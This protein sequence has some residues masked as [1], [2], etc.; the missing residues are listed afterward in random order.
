MAGVIV[1]CTDG[2]EVSV[3]ALRAGLTVVDPDATFVVVS[4]AEPS[5]PSLL[6]GTGMAAGTVSP[7]LFERLEAER[8]AAAATAAAQTVATLGLDGARTEVLEGQ[9]GPSLC[10]FAAGEGASGIVMGT[11][12]HGG[13]RRAVL[14]SVSDYVVRH[15]PCPVVVAQPPRD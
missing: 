2:S 3:A 12:G 8:T 4:V 7:E 6:T 1:L 10:T 11:R 14:G 15:A 13:L 9:P 5:D